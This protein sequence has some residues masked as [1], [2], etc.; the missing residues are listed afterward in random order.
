M[1]TPGLAQTRKQLDELDDLIQR[2]LTL[3][4]SH[5]DESEAEAAAAT[6]RMSPREFAPLPYDDIAG[7]RVV[8]QTVTPAHGQAGSVQGW[9][10]EFPGGTRFIEGNPKPPAQE[11]GDPKP[12]EADRFLPFADEVYEPAPRPAL[13]TPGPLPAEPKRLSALAMPFWLLNRTFDVLLGWI[14]YLGAFTRPVG[15]NVLG[16]FGVLMI[17]GAIAWA[18]MDYREFRWTAPDAPPIIPLRK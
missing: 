7:A 4:L 13:P 6:L 12:T 3:P 5:M 8:E 18:V 15:K 16:A 10:I 1:A 17:L 14:P 11:Y 2:M 9:R